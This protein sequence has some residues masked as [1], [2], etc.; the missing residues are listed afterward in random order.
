[1]Y[2]KLMAQKM[3]QRPNGHGR[4]ESY[5]HRP[6]VRMSNTL[7]LPG[8]DNP[9]EII[10][11]V[12]NGLFVAM[13]GGGQV[14]TVN[15]D[16]MFEVTEGYEIKNGKLGDPVRGATL[17]G[18]ALDV[19]SKIDKV[20]NDIGY[21]TGTCGKDGQGVPVSDGM[22]TVRISEMVVGGEVKAI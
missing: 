12:N 2:D 13:M 16:F 3:G 1:M 21:S 22:P 9:D 10:Q 5:R 14:N 18:S 15:G 19:L 7:L 20:G 4:R 6:I 8:K 17:T 11:S